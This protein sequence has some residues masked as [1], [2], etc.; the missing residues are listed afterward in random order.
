MGAT[1]GDRTRR[2]SEI[3]RASAAD[4]AFL[5]MDAGKVPNNSACCCCSIP[6]LASTS[7][8]SA[9][10]ITE[11]IAAVPRLR[12]KLIRAPF[13]CGGPVWI[14][15]P[16]FDITTTFGRCPAHSRMIGRRLLDVALAAI[17]TPL[18]DEGPAVDS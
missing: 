7:R 10:L 17:T 14:D 1:A 18:N 5:A 6:R 16:V 3:E 4:R 12:Q 8:S 11:R 9:T 15:D 13:G 2:G